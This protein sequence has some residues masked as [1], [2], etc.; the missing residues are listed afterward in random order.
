MPSH[1][2]SV[3]GQLSLKVAHD[4][5]AVRAAA[6]QVR[7][8]LT[9]HGLPEKE[10]WACELA[11][12]EGCNNAIQHVSGT[13]RRKQILLEITCNACHVEL[14]IN[15][16]TEGFELPQAIDLPPSEEESGRGLYLIKSLMDDVRYLRRESSNCLVLQ[17]NR[18][19]I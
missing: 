16:H 8:F 19:G 4:F 13:A 1:Q 6:T 17:K 18:T 14:C 7:G 11:L 15:D 12:V 5:A 2:P 10:I 3:P 9:L